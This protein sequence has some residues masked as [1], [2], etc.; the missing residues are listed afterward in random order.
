MASTNVMVV[1]PIALESTKGRTS[2]GRVGLMS[3]PMRRALESLLR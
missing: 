3:A 2:I 1:R